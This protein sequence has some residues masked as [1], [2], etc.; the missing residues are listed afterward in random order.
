MNP[1]LWVQFTVPGIPVPQGSLRAFRGAGRHPIIT[2]DN[3]R[4][5]P[6]K[7]HVTVLAREALAGKSFC[8]DQAVAVHIDFVMPRPPSAPRRRELP[9]TKPDV[10]KLVRAILDAL[11]DAGAWEDDCQVVSVQ[12]KKDYGPQ[13]QA[14][15]SLAAAGRWACPPT[16]PA[17]SPAV[18]ADPPQPQP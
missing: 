8:R 9:I 16:R 6:W 7:L 18:P 2:S 15:I 4:T 12:A 5:R 3:K 1:A 11:T 10:D 14:I 13:P 17:D